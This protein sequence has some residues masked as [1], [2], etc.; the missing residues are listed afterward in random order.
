MTAADP[1]ATAAMLIIGGLLMCYSILVIAVWSFRN[2]VRAIYG[3]TRRRD[4]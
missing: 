1:V 2:R 4:L 3:E